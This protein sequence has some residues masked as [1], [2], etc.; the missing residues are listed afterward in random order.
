M[1]GSRDRTSPERRRGRAE[2]LLEG[3]ELGI[4][5]AGVGH[6]LVVGAA[7]DHPALAEHD[8]LLAVADG[9]E[10]VGDDQAGAAAAAEVVVDQGLGHRVERL[11]ASSRMSNA[12][13]RIR[14]RAISMPLPLAAREVPRPF[15]QP[16]GIPVPQADDLAVDAGVHRRARHL[17]LGDRVIPERQVLADGPA[18][19]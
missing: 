16:R 1:V 14:A 3:L 15:G 4:E 13:L 17:A 19:E 10:P 9:A 18:E 6:Q 12:G 5:A 2:T 8:D 11:V 7:L